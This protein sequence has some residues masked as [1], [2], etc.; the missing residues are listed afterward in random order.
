MNDIFLLSV[1]G[2]GVLMFSFLVVDFIEVIVNG[3]FDLFND[4]FFSDNKKEKNVPK[5]VYRQ[6]SEL[7]QKLLKEGKAEKVFPAFFIEDHTFNGSKL[8]FKSHEEKCEFLSICDIIEYHDGFI[9]DF[10]L[11]QIAVAKKL[12]AKI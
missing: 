6:K 12:V 8:L 3:V 7:I 10:E 1:L 5:K 2:F 11:K 4:L 9:T